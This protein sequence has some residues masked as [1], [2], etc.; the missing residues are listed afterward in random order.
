LRGGDA[1]VSSSVSVLEDGMEAVSVGVVI[2]FTA[3]LLSFLTPCVLP[4]VPSY[5]TFVTGLRLEEVPHARRHT[6]VHAALFILGFSLI[7]LALGATATALGR[8]L[9]VHRL[10]LTR[11]GGLLVILFALHLLG[12]FNLRFLARERRVHLTDKP[13]GYLGSVLVGIAFG[14]GWSPCLGPILGGILTYTASQAELGRGMV[15]LG[16]Y[17]LGLAVP[18][19]LAA[20][21]VDRF[22]AFFQRFRSKLVWVDRAAGVLLLVVG[23]LMLTDYFSTLSGFLQTLTPSALRNRI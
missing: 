21:A 18:F 14:A 2:A 16:S 19:L 9:V 15:L 1:T 4:L 11:V 10:W 6:L 8:L 5:V 22:L 7:F 20:L 17:S 3:G 13:L 23:I 12:A